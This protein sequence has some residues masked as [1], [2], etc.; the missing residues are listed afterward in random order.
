[1]NPTTDTPPLLDPL[2]DRLLVQMVP[3]EQI[4]AGGIHIPE[5][6]QMTA[7]WGRVMARGPEVEDVQEGDEVYVTRLQ[8]THLV[9]HG[10]DYIIV[11][12]SECLAR[13]AA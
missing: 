9:L 13:R 2:S 4:S 6:S 8:G 11:R 1:M 12:E 5:V 10:V 7:N 3:R